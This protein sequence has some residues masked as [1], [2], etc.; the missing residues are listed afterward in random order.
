MHNF[1]SAIRARLTSPLATVHPEDTT[2][3]KYSFDLLE[4]GPS[5]PSSE[6]DNYSL[7]SV[8]GL[9][10]DMMRAEQGVCSEREVTRVDRRRRR[11]RSGSSVFGS[12]AESEIPPPYKECEESDDGFEYT[13]P[14]TDDTPESS[15][16]STSP[17]T[18]LYT[19]DSDSEKL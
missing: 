5:K 7:R 8:Y 12:G 13:P 6:D 3:E 17:R 19:R 1:F 18:S 14:G 4:E 10:S 15:V 2:S 9:V 16:I 11:V